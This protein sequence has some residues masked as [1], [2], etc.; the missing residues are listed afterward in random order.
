MSTNCS[1]FSWSPSTVDSLGPTRIVAI[2]AII[3]H[4][5]FW[6]EFFVC[7]PLRQRNMGSL[8]IYLLTD[9]VLLSRFF[10]LTAIRMAELCL[11]T[12][13]RDILCYFEA[14]SKFY[15]NTVQSYLMLAF[16]I[17]RYKQLVLN[18]N[19]YV[20]KPRLIIFAHIAIIMLPTINLIIQ[21]LSKGAVLWRRRGGSCDIQYVSLLL[22]LFNLF[23][24]YIIP[25][26]S[27]VII[28]TLDIRH[29]SSIRG[30]ASQQIIYLR[31]KRQRILLCQTISFYSIWL[32]LWSPD[33]IAFQFINV[34]TDPAIFTSL[35]SY[36]GIALDPLIVS[37]VDIRFL[38]P[39]KIIWN[40][41]KQQ[42]QVAA[43]GK[44]RIL[45]P[46]GP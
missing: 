20:E 30:V 14:S 35:L 33:I 31:R 8:F 41:M 36:V 40:K 26:I 2:I 5:F 22:Q 34:N 13:A 43:I 44:G 10:I 27:N 21:F 42:Q 4:G 6:I 17:C 28:L 39:W 1:I 15:L 24:V 19:V 29:V 7:S 9:F 23:L 38:T 45:P 37:I 18:R 46:S 12:T 16:N 11:F 32:L 3:I 25:V